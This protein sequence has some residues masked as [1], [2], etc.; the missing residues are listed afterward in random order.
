MIR[1][2][3]FGNLTRERETK[4]IKLLNEKLRLDH[5]TEGANN[6]RKI[7]EEYAD[8][9]K[10]PGDSLTATTATEH[11]IPTPSIPKGRAITL[12]NY[13]LPESQGQEVKE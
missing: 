12:R 13:R 8:V 7:C 6:I 10:L 2:Q 4:R 3:N 9:F 11:S 5:I 1:R